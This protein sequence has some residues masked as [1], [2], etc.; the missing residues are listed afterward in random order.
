MCPSGPGSR[1]WKILQRTC[2]PAVRRRRGGGR[3]LDKDVDANGWEGQSQCKKNASSAGKNSEI[4][5]SSHDDATQLFCLNS[6]SSALI[7]AVLDRCAPNCC[8]RQK[9]NNCTLRNIRSSWHSRAL[10]QLQ[11]L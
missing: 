11:R 8:S 2:K 10:Q 4:S 1:R 3:T 7:D 9:P 5:G 6:S